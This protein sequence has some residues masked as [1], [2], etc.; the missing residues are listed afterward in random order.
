[1]R[2]NTDT[3]TKTGRRNAF[4]LAIH[5]HAAKHATAVLERFDKLGE[6]ARAELR[7]VLETAYVA[8]ACAMID[9]IEGR[10]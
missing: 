2:L 9:A 10:K 5:D 4:L 1:M 7:T 8:G 3:K 6:P